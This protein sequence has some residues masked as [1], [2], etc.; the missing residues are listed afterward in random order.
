MSLQGLLEPGRVLCNVEARSRK[1][2]L[3]IL[4][5]L[6]A[7]AENDLTAGEIF[8]S[9]VARERLGSTALGCGVA[10]PHGRVPGIDG[11]IAAFVRLSQ[12]V[13]FDAPDGI[14]VRLVLGLL[15]PEQASEQHLGELSSIAKRLSRP[16]L[17]A[18]L[19]DAGS[20]SSIFEALTAPA[21]PAQAG[22]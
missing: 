19:A 3:E 14:P 10:L 2:V 18:A 9:L 22:A 12:G 21:E 8:D 11:S 7:S 16:E 6:L 1:H 15:V 5:E 13:E 17:R 4:S 20:S